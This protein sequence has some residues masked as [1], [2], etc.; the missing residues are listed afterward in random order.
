LYFTKSATGELINKN[1]D[2]TRAHHIVATYDWNISGNHHLR[3]EPYLQQ[4]FRV[5][6]VAGSSFS[7]INLQRDWFIPDRLENSGKG[8]NYGIDATFEKYMSQGFYYMF[9][10]SLFDSRYKAGD[11]V[12]RNTRYNRRYVFNLLGGKEWMTGR[13][14]QTIFN[15]NVRLSYQGGDRY[16]PVD[17]T[18][19]QQVGEVMY[20][21][22]DAFSQQYTPSFICHFTVACK[23][24]RKNTAHEFAL[25]VI[26]ATMSREY[27]G[28]KYNFTT[29]T[30]DVDSE[31]TMVPNISYKIE[32]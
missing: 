5:P 9:T 30:V 2:F 17:L 4:L 27:L 31:F 29:R 12:W 32:F 23:I 11:G 18:A 28:H 24:N 19:S 16:S 25:K 3:I 20:L 7:L 10:A 14:R 21:E 6:V 15:A 22:S 26:N 13:K 1:L 8:F